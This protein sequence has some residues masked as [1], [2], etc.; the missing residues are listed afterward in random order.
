M[1][2]THTIMLMLSLSLSY[3]HTDYYSPSRNRKN[4]FGVFF[5]LFS[6]EHRPFLTVLLMLRY[7]NKIF[8]KVENV[9]YS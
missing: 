5:G 2:L 7:R 1:T 3:C 6:V 9:W 8:A 4:P